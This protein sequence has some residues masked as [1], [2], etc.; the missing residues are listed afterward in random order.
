MLKMLRRAV[1]AT[2]SEGAHAPS[3]PIFHPPPP[4]P[5][6]M[7]TGPPDFAGLGAQKSGTTWWFGLLQRHPAVH[8]P[9]FT[10]QRYPR[11]FPKE[12]H[13]FDHCFRAPFGEQEVAAYHRWF[14][15]PD[16][17]V[18]GEWTPRYLVDPWTAPLL[19]RAAPRCRL[20]ILLR[21]PVERFESGMAQR[22]RN[23]PLSADDAVA[24]LARGLYHSQI[25]EWLHFFSRSQL[26]L[27]QFE[28]CRREP[29]AEL[30]RTFHFL[31]LEDHHIPEVDLFRRVNRR[32]DETRYR[33]PRLLEEA[34]I[35]RY[36]PE[37]Q[38]LKELMPDLDL[39]LWSHFEH[40][41]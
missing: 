7:V 18:T 22:Q 13:F 15:R 25:T 30:R 40:L 41:A 10:G 32:R 34:L 29:A 5:P 4:C 28:R 35:R 11:S 38:R 21:D 33:T 31:G 39:S 1:R 8:V 37:V 9:D 14:P 17:M 16:G 36:E 26:L 3:D 23:H 6:G 20:L 19:A 24:H 12:R 27:L 2:M